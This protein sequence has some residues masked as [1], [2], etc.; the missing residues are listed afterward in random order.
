M[1][2][3]PDTMSLF[4][5]L[6]PPK[7]LDNFM[8]AAGF[9]SIADA[10][11]AISLSNAVLLN[12]GRPPLEVIDELR[13][14][15]VILGEGRK[16]RGCRLDV[17]VREGRHHINLEVQ[18]SSLHHMADRMVFNSS[19]LLG[20]NTPSGTEYEDLPK[21]TIISLLDFVYRKS[22][23]DFHQPFG[24][25]YEKGPELVTD[26]S[27]YHMLEIPKFRLL[28]P[29]I[30]IPL[31]R[32]LLYLDS[33]YKDPDNP[34]VKE[35]L[36]MDQ[37]LF[38][39][40][41]QFQR[42]ASDPNTLYDY[43]GYVLERMDEKNRL[44]TARLEGRDEGRDEGRVEGRV[45]GREEGRQEGIYTV[46][47]NLLGINMPVDEIMGVTGLTREEVEKLRAEAP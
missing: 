9:Q 36:Q 16:L 41:Q 17:S 6:P 14:E 23:P 44:Y 7:P 13:C 31:H 34:I 25:Y 26:K 12:A 42:N 8:F 39:F 38:Q 30:N 40:A 27:D 28:T 5:G 22:H 45:E 11:S 46:A 32:W 1:P 4:G 37:G 10:P 47:G 19:R 29:D 2:Q 35:A 18:L 3:Q 24:L 43:Y 33:G 21:T 15:Q 20:V